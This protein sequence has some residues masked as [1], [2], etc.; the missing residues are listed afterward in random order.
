MYMVF[1]FSVFLLYYPALPTSPPEGFESPWQSLT[2]VEQFLCWDPE[3]KVNRY[4]DLWTNQ[5]LSIA[6]RIRPW[7]TSSGRPKPFGY[8]LYHHRV[9]YIGIY[10]MEKHFTTDCLPQ[11]N[12]K[13]YFM[14][15]F[16]PAHTF[17]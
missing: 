5:S 17:I 15:C 10:S 12:K 2:A 6:I 8:P 7:C 1:I 11:D 14:Y 16:I 3:I 9:H 4:P 13:L